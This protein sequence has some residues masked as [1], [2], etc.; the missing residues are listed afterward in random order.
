MN[1]PVV[2]RT[3]PLGLTRATN[4][5]S[6]KATTRNARQQQQHELEK[7]TKRKKEKIFFRLL[8]SADESDTSSHIFKKKKNFIQKNKFHRSTRRLPTVHFD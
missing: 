4:V 5:N 7:I 6:P 8:T 2:E 3:R 1:E